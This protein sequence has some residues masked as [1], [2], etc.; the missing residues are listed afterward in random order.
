[1]VCRLRSNI[2]VQYDILERRLNEPGQQYLALKDRPTIADIATLPFAMEAT[3]ELFGLEFER[4]PKLQEWSVRM[5]EREAVK[6]AW[7]RVAGFGHGEKE[8]GMLEA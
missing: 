3:A 4:W 5:S 2:T 7:Q 1:M 8:Y 6:R